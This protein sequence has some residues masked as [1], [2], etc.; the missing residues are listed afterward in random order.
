MYSKLRLASF[1][2]GQ[3]S[4]RPSFTIT[5]NVFLMFQDANYT[6]IGIANETECEA[7]VTSSLFNFNA[8]CPLE[9]CTFNGVY[10]PPV[11]GQFYVSVLGYSL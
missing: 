8:S 5:Q 9:P 10:Q 11:F 3:S 7:A 2:N 6:F 1:Q 4:N